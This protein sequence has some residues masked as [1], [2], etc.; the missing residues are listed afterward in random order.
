MFRRLSD[1]TL[2][3]RPRLTGG[4]SADNPHAPWLSG[5]DTDLS[6]ATLRHRLLLR[7]CRPLT[8]QFRTPPPALL[9]L[10]DVAA[11]P[12]P[13]RALQAASGPLLGTLTQVPAHGLLPRDPY[14][15]CSLFV[16]MATT[17]L[18]PD[19]SAK[20]RSHG[21]FSLLLWD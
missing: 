11:S 10:T 2:G 19:Y 1:L 15:V 8:S 13:T 16:L 6:V 17:Q 20:G 5:Q 21:F 12:A 7:S 3:P 18:R 9:E 14:S 4:W